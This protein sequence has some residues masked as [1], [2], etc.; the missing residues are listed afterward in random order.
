M[1]RFSFLYA[2]NCVWWVYL[3]VFIKIL[4]SSLNVV[5][6]VYKH[7]S[8]IC[9]DKFPVPQIDRKT[10]QVKEQWHGRFY[11]QSVWGKL[12]ILNIENI[13]TCGWITKLE[14]RK[15]Q[16]V[17]IFFNIC[18]ISEKKFEFLISQGSVATCLRWCGQFRRGFVA[19]F[20]RFLAVNKFWKPVK[21][22]QSYREF[23][24]R[25]FYW[26]TV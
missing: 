1:H 5:L 23:K 12:T 17:C 21:I 8:D 19:N 24:G 16:F 3:C 2:C 25:N 7:C 15:M 14:A 18:W 22:W 11:L 13:K 9:C 26:Y 4:F 6:I 10:K 20:M